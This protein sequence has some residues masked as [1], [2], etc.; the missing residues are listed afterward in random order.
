MLSVETPSVWYVGIPVLECS[1]CSEYGPCDEPDGLSVDIP[2][3]DL[4]CVDISTGDELCAESG[5]KN[6]QINGVI[7][8]KYC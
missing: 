5:E 2:G 8:M 3:L 1:G 6:I 4:C 7:L